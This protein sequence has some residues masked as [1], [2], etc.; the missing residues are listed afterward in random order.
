MA[1]VP[2]ACDRHRFLKRFQELVYVLALLG[3]LVD[4]SAA[5]ANQPLAAADN[6]FG[7]RLFHELAK[8]QPATN[9]CI[10]PY[11]TATV[12]HMVGN[13]AAGKTKAEMQQVLG[14]A[15]MPFDDIN[16]ANR[17]L[18]QSL[19]REDTHHVILTTANAIWYRKEAQ[20]KAKFVAT[21]RQFYGATVEALNFDDPRA[22]DVIN[23][24]VG[25]KTK[26][27]IQRL[28]DGMI[29]PVNT[30]MF[31]ADAIYFKGRWSSPFAARYTKNRAF[32][33][34]DG[35][36]KVIPMMLQSKRL[37]YREG[38]GYKAVRL[39]Y[40]GDNLSMY[41]FLPDVHTTPQTILGTLSGEAGDARPSRAL[42]PSMLIWCCRSSRLNTAWNSVNPC[43]LLV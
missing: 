36:E 14:T 10:S 30:R 37:E 39:P 7:F 29:N 26:G 43:R 4:V 3:T 22:V 1:I 24:W 41:I 34:S 17:D 6:A 20:V 27:K 13:G 38:G 42:A 31:L 12:L 19:A 18:A 11:S 15:G 25:D 23:G 33:S 32:H 8:A 2:R 40:E 28:A 21:N 9:I 5:S 35:G 16:A